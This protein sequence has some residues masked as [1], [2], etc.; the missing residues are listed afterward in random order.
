MWHYAQGMASAQTGKAAPAGEQSRALQKIIAGGETQSVLGKDGHT[1]LKIAQ[2]ILVAKIAD[3]EGKRKLTLASLRE[4]MK[5]QDGMRYHEPPDWYFPVSQALGDAYL[6]WGSADKAARMYRQALHRHPENGWS[7]FGLGASLRATGQVA[8]AAKV[9]ER[10][11]TA[12]QN[13]DIAKPVSLFWSSQH[14][15]SARNCQTGALSSVAQVS[16]AHFTQ[17]DV[18]EIPQ[19]DAAPADSEV[20]I[21]SLKLPLCQTSDR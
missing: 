1:L 9:D 20:A 6:K 21:S 2:A 11:R 12:W 4:A 10:F 14:S 8:E 13:A 18:G 17:A 7:L 19:P 5:L 3:S 16:H 15:R